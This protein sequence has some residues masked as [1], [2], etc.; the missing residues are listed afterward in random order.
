M[1]LYC[2]S[3]TFSL[4]AKD[5]ILLPSYKGSTLRGGFGNAFRKVVCAL[6]KSDCSG[7]LLK[8]KCVYSYVFETPPP[9][10]S[11]IMT[12]YTNA[13][14][15]FVIEPPAERKQAYKPGDEIHFGLVLTGRA[16]DYL[17]YFIYT[18]DELGKMGIGKGRGKYLLNKVSVSRLLS[19]PLRGGDEG[20]GEIIYDSTTKTL[21]PVRP[22]LLNLD[23]EKLKSDSRGVN[24]EH[25]T[26]SIDFLTPTRIV[27]DG[28]LTLELEFHMLVRQLLRRM[29]LLS[30]FHCGGDPSGIDFKGIIE[31]AKEVR[32]KKRSLKWYDW[33]RYSTRQN[34]KMKMGGFIGEI[35]FEGNIGPFMPLIEAGAVLHV[36]K[37]TS[38]GLGRYEY[39]EKCR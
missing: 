31:A 30:Y 18:F 33:E 21:N 34:A 4:V 5:V 11:R 36:G 20:D 12:K 17:P 25:R 28:S 38:F 23:F 32:V 9:A 3:F 14:H 16:I 8:E 24:L 19:P 37:G 22:S 35:T 29:A 27:Y 39:S 26:L 2:S 10:D 15:P 6:K 13:P 7:C 1:H